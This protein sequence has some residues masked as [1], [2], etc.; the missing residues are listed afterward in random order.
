MDGELYKGVKKIVRPDEVHDII[1]Q[2][3][4]TAGHPGI[5]TT[6]SNVCKQGVYAGG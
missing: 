1:K 6:Y 3:H 4:E 5:A 2:T